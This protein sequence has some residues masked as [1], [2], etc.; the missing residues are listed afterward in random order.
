MSEYKIVTDMDPSIF[1]A[2]DIRG[3]VAENMDSDVVY[4]LGLVIG[5]VARDAG[6]QEIVTGR[7]GRLSGPELSS[8]LIAGLRASGCKV[9]DVGQVPTPVLY[10]ATQL[11]KVNSGVMLTGSH[12]PVGYNGLKMIINDKT[13]TTVAIEKLYQRI[14]QKGF[15]QGQG[16][17]ET[18]DIIEDY[19]SRI[20]SDIQ[21]MRPLKIVIDCANGV[22]GSV[23]PQLFNAIGCEVIELYTEVDGNFPNHHPDPT[24]PENMKDLIAHVQ[25]NEAD[26]GV[27][28]DGDG[29]RIGVV[30]QSGKMIWADQ[31]MM[32][33][34]MDLLERKPGADI[35]FD[36]KCSRHLPKVIENNGGN[37]VMWK[38]GHSLLKNKMQ[39]MNA[40]LA[41]EMSGHIFF[42][43]RW[44]GFD[45]GLYAAARLLEILS[46]DPRPSNEVFD[47][48]PQSISTPEIKIPIG[49][50]EKFIFMEKFIKK[51]TFPGARIT[52]IDGL[53]AD[54]D[55]GWGLLRLSN[56]TP[57]LIMRFEADKAENLE[58]LQNQFREQ[59]L[60]IEPNL[61][62][63]F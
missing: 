35:L 63:P 9:I 41:G 57:C 2:Y 13:L 47:D 38:T 62:L 50:I 52:T 43:E 22:A 18:L 10:F 36:V 45:D 54:F 17:I 40:E 3:I 59:M 25:K 1:R 24:R 31:L 32:L 37:P 8:A 44:F 46:K 4:T 20:A 12:N 34:A 49:E 7:D 39:E 51:A 61:Q 42:K 11:L 16:E 6:Q 27:G 23:A 29:D 56:T 26:L 30:T 55:Q 33:F 60:E 5:S 19:I 15:H 48:L 21:L 14:Q 28:F 53:R 58:T